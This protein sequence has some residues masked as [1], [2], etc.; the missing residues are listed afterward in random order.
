MNNVSIEPQDYKRTQT[1]ELNAQQ[2]G[3]RHGE[4][5]CFRGYPLSGSFKQF[6]DTDSK[7]L[8]H[9]DSDMIFYETEG[10]S[11]IKEGIRIMEENNDILCVLPKGGPPTPDRSLHQGTTPYKIDKKRRIYLFKNFTSRHYLI[12]RERFKSLIPMQAAWLSWREP[13]KSRIFGNGKFLCWE[14]IV[15]KALEKS[16]LWRADLMTDK[17]WSLHPAD[18]SEKFYNLLPQI[19]DCVNRNQFPKEQRGHYDLLINDWENFL[20]YKN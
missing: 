18:R 3:F 4:S 14:T 1:K 19:L 11:W 15:E 9:L 10:F 20:N 5:H 6:L 12:H 17:T 13:I 7:Y 16:S 8:L 2:F